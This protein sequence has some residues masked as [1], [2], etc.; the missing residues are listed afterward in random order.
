MFLRCTTIFVNHISVAQKGVRKPY[1]NSNGQKALQNA[2]FHPL[3]T[4]T[5]GLHKSVS[6]RLDP[7]E[8]GSQSRLSIV[9][10]NEINS[11][12]GVR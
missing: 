4:E 6:V 1:I 8:M 12:F 2:K 5:S 10:I 11:I 9:E 3:T 7:M